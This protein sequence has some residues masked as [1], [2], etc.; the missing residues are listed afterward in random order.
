MRIEK[1]YFCSAPV[2]PGHG[3]QFVRNDCKSFRFCTSKCHANFKMK[4]NP[5]KVKWTKAFRKSHGKEM[6]NDTTFEFERRR[7]VPVRYDRELVGKTIQAMK[8]VQDIKEK[9]EQRYYAM[10]M[11]NK[12]KQEKKQALAELERD[13]S[14]VKATNA[15][16]PVKLKVQEPVKQTHQNA[17]KKEKETIGVKKKDQQKDQQQ[18]K[19][20]G[21]FF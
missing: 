7:N 14:L 21:Y 4:R 3:M 1:C 5:R 20:N 11:R 12:A 6:R 13:I 16:K 2:Y 19:K 10:R 18:Q 8:T 17:Q 15:T 9:R